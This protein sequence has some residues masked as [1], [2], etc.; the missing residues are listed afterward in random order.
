V[1]TRARFIDRIVIVTGGANG[2][3]RATAEDFAREGARV[4]IADIDIQAGAQSCERITV[5]GGIARLIST[6]VADEHSIA[7]MVLATMGWGH[8]SDGRSKSAA[9]RELT[10]SRNRNELWV[11][12]KLFEQAS[13]FGKESARLAPQAEQPGCRERLRLYREEKPYRESHP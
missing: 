12:P 5:S 4:V 13:Q 6:D 8:P 1:S 2:V 9:G 11:A 10:M 7:A 3:G